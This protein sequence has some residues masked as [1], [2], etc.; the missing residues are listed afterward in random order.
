MKTLSSELDNQRLGEMGE[1]GEKR[2]MAGACKRVR[3]PRG[4]TEKGPKN[5]HSRKLQQQTFGKHD[6]KREEQ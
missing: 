4:G 3:R 2:E 5:V 6:E 1:E